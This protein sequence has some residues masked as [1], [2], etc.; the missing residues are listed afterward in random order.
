ML[1]EIHNKDTKYVLSVTEVP[2]SKS[3]VADSG[4]VHQ[5]PLQIVNLGYLFAAF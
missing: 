2:A 1:S 5:E 4:R 3:A